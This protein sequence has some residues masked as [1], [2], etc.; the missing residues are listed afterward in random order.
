[1][2]NTESELTKLFKEL[3]QP[4]TP[5][6]YVACLCAYNNSQLHGEWLDVDSDSDEIMDGIKSM[7]SRSPMNKIEVCE[8]WA[9]HDYE[10]FHGISISEHEGIER[11]VELA[12]KIEEHG[13]AFAVYL[14][15]WS[16]EDI[17][18]FEDKYQGCYKSKQDFAEEYYDDAG[19]TDQIEKAGLK[20]CYIDFEAI[21]RDMFMDGYTGIDKG[22]EKFY[23][24]CDC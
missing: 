6:I 12:Q 2:S 22:Y 18:N 10:G 16:C 3:E 23:V 7:L 17:D 9:I 21:A 13:E 20:A 19:M 24:F 11:I 15:H 14:E 1:M 8:E 4:E 5:R